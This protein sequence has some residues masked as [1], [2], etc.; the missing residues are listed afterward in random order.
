MSGIEDH[1][2][3]K[4]FQAWWPLEKRKIYWIIVVFLKE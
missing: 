4:V 3:M 2:K 1:A